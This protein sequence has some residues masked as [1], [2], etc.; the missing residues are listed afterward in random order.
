MRIRLF[1]A[2]RLLLLFRMLLH[3]RHKL[4]SPQKLDQTRA[5][6][7]LP[8]LSFFFSCSS[9]I[10][11]LCVLLTINILYLYNSAHKSQN[12]PCRSLFIILNLLSF[13][14]FNFINEMI[15]LGID[16][17]FE[18]MGCAVLE[19]NSSGEKLLYSS[20]LVSKR[21]DTH[22]KRLCVCMLD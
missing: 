9:F 16:P 22:E 8:L 10:M 13:K 12:L 11:F 4:H 15:I 2:D 5:L 14:T 17:G 20:C 6:P 1:Y 7:H 21:T 18:R 3:I 19:K